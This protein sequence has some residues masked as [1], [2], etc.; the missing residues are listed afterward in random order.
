MKISWTSPSD[1]NSPITSYKIVIRD[2][3]GT[4]FYESTTYCD[5]SVAAIRDNQYCEIPMSALWAGSW[6]LELNQLV[7][8]KITATNA[9]GTSDESTVNTVGATI[10]TVPKTPP[11]VVRSGS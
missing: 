7:A 3:I 2:K 8:A 5:G 6:T 9:F 1:N 10:K 4:T 11:T